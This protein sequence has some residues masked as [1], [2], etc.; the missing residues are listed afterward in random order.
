MVLL[1]IILTQKDSGAALIRNPQNRCNRLKK[2][3]NM[4]PLIAWLLGVPISV[5]IILW[6]IGVF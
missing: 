3:M 1:F 5:I 4:Y 6:L 2:E